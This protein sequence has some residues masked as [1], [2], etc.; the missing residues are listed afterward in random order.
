M[1]VLDKKKPINES[2]RKI[3]IRYGD[4][5]DPYGDF[6][7]MKEF[8]ALL[9]PGGL[10]LLSVPMW[11]KD[12]QSQMLARLYGPIRLPMLIKGWE[13]LGTVNKGAWSK[14]VPFLEHW[15]WQPILVKSIFHFYDSTL[16]VFFLIFKKLFVFYV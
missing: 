13:Y 2:K 3:I 12:K 16:L 4:P 8:N 9:K 14:H 7:A 10:L 6:H 1:I 15:G 5:I 11:P